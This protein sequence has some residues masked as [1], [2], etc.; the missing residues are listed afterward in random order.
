MGHIASMAPKT[1]TLKSPSL[2][3]IRSDKKAPLWSRNVKFIALLAILL[4]VPV[5]GSC[6]AVERSPSPTTTTPSAAFAL[7]LADTGEVLLTESDIEAY[8]NVNHALVLNESGILKWNSHLTYQDIPKLDDSLFRR[9]FIVKVEGKELCRGTFWSNLSS[10]SAEGVVIVD[11]ILKLG[12]VRHSISIES[13]YPSSRS[14]DPSIDSALQRVLPAPRDEFAESVL[15]VARDSV[16]LE[17]ARYASGKTVSLTRD[18][19]EYGPIVTAL[20][21]SATQQ[22]T[23]KT[24]VVIENGT[25]KRIDVTIPYARGII[26]TFKL[27]DGTELKFNCT[28]SDVWFET[29]RATYQASVNPDLM[30]FLERL[31]G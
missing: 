3:S 19:P 26:L 24:T 5:L 14:L 18:T 12:A 10:T 16:R 30:P 25:P 29:D 1:N 9:K 20:K 7:I 17:I 4:L 15:K 23:S 11:S 31:L 28:S 22:V 21:S 13:G 27:N 8:D 6:R 2:A